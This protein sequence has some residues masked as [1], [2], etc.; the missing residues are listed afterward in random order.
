MSHLQYA[1]DVIFFGKWSTGNLKNLMKILN[2]F[3]VASGLKINISK[4]KLYGVGVGEDEIQAWARGIGC[5]CGSF[6]FVYLGLPVGATM[7]KIDDWKEVVEKMKNKLASWKAKVV[8]FGGRLTL[9]K[10]VLG[11]LLLYF[12]LLFRASRR[13]ISELER[14]RSSFFWEGGSGTNRNK[15]VAWVKW[16]KV[17]KDFKK[18]GLNV[19]SP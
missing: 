1:D 10:S 5:G 6:P 17:V 13:M 3:Y 4:R 8:Q 11:S 7:N 12:F 9:V 19:G 16:V 14:V 2:C 18:G 15:G